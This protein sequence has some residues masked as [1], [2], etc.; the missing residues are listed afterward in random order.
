MV[1]SLIVTVTLSTSPAFSVLLAIPVA[2]AMATPDT[3]ATDVATVRVLVEALETLPAASITYSWYRPSV[4]GA[5]IE[6]AVPPAVVM[7]APAT[8]L[9]VPAGANQTLPVASPELTIVTASSAALLTA[10]A[11]TVSWLVGAK[12]STR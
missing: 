5:R 8:K 10:A 3:L 4:A 1:A 11:N 6:L 2:L 9:V 12:V 7:V